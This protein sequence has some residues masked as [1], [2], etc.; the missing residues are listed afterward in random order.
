MKRNMLKKKLLDGCVVFGPFVNSPY[1]SMIEILGLVGFD[2]AIVDTEHGP[3]DILTSEDL[4]RAAENG[5][6]TPVIRVRKSEPSIILRALDICGSVQVPHIETE[7]D[8]I[9]TALSSKYGP[10]GERGLSLYVRSASYGFKREG[11]T[12]RLNEDS[13]V[14][15]QVEGIT[16]LKNLKKIAQVQNIDVIFLGPYDISNSLGI[17]GKINDERVTKRM[18]KAVQQIKQAGKIAGTYADTPEVANK[19]ARLGVQY[20][21]TCVDMGIYLEACRAFMS[22]LRQ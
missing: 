1:G 13:L 15:A 4:C 21:S 3:L 2:F 11:V 20:V 9:R 6:L 17:P 18:E 16:G 10:V 19:W 8:A 22:T 14:I 12:E 7:E 5:G